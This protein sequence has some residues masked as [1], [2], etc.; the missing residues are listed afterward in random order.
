ME[1]LL[2]LSSTSHLKERD[3]SVLRFDDIFGFWVKIGSTKSPRD[4]NSSL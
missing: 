2:C 1:V 4:G 3:F